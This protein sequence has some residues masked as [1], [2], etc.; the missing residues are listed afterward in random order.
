MSNIACSALCQVLSEL[1][2]VAFASNARSSF[3][4]LNMLQ[5]SLIIVRA[6]SGQGPHTT[7]ALPAP[8]S[9][10]PAKS[11]IHFVPGPHPTSQ[12][13]QTSGTMMTSTG[14]DFTRSIVENSGIQV[15]LQSGSGRSAG[16]STRS[17]FEL[18]DET[19]MVDPSPQA[20]IVD[21]EK[22]A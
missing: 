9:A 8:G 4:E 20:D 11:S 6:G 14:T 15:H 18:K 22:Q 17:D 19:E 1:L 21:L 3:S 7:W 10:A 13:T 2:Y 5:F 12:F 16:T